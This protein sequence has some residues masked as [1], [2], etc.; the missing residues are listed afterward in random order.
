[1][2]IDRFIA[3]VVPTRG[4]ADAVT[5]ADV[6]RIVSDTP[7]Q[8]A[9]QDFTE[10]EVTDYLWAGRTEF[11]AAAMATVLQAAAAWGITPRRVR[12]LAAEERIPGAV[13]IGRDWL[14]PSDATKP[15]DARLRK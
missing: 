4:I 13:K 3:E 12:I 7:I 5:K 10:E 8:W 11:A 1:M 9:D 14:I 15:T 2:T 6:R